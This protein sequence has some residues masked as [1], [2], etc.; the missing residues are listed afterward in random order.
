MSMNGHCNIVGVIVC[1]CN[2]IV[3]QCYCS[4]EVNPQFEKRK[5]PEQCVEYLWHE[6]NLSTFANGY[7]IS[8]SYCE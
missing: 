5:I 3:D 7:R 4:Q 2:M 8:L 6:I 1:S